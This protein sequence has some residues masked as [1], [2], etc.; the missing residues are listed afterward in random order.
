MCVCVYV[1]LL[2]VFDVIDI[3]YSHAKKSLTSG[4]LLLVQVEVEWDSY[5]PQCW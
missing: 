2:V 5:K 4:G 3:A 1:V